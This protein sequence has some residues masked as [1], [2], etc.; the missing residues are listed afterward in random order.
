MV[1]DSSVFIEFLRAKNKKNTTLYAISSETQLFISSVTLYELLMGATNKAKTDDI[2]LIT[3]DLTI[4][5]FDKRT[6]VKAAQIYHKLR[7][8]NRMIEFR[9]IFIAATC[10]AN[11]LPV[12]TLNKKHFSRIE[13][14][15]IA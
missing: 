6:A 5:D 14:L 9:D 3:G 13:D 8:E 1:I 2:N 12:K 15:L 11:K 7:T 10:I 4:L